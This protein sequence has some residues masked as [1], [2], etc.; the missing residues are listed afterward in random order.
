MHTGPRG[1]TAS[2]S[3][4][5]P[6]ILSSEPRAPS[7]GPNETHYKEPRATARGRSTSHKHAQ[8]KAGG[9]QT[10]TIGQLRGASQRLRR[11]LLLG[12]LL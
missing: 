10:G 1:Q 11:G 4:G 2:R 6:R 5:V 8:E 7:I 3:G 9:L 12:L